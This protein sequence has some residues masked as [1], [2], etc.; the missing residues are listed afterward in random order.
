M[1]LGDPNVGKTCLTTL[2]VKEKVAEPTLNTIAYDFHIKEVF[3][4]NG[5][6]VKVRAFSY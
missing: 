1:L 4:A 2:F 3:I 6:S 5:I